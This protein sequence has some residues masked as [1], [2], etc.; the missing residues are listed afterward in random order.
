MKNNIKYYTTLDWFH[1][2]RV[3]LRKGGE[4]DYEGTT[5]GLDLDLRTTLSYHTYEYG[6]VFTFTFLGFGFELALLSI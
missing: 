3:V 6:H 4:D 1:P 2:F 5:Y